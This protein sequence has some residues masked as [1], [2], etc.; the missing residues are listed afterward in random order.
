MEWN[1]VESIFAPYMT[2]E[3]ISSS[4][5]STTTFLYLVNL[6][7]KTSV[8]GGNKKHADFEITYHEPSLSSACLLHHLWNNNS[9]WLQLMDLGIFTHDS[10]FQRYLKLDFPSV[11]QWWITGNLE[12]EMTSSIRFYLFVEPCMFLD[13]FCSSWVS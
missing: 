8:H 11:L 6:K 3:S 9:S 2:T 12:S 5:C 13:V 10:L 4:D 7:R 1:I